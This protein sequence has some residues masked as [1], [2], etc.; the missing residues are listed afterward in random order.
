MINTPNSGS[1]I[2]LAFSS[3]NTVFASSKET[4]CL[5]RFDLA[6]NVPTKKDQILNINYVK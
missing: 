4:L 1:Y 3:S 2:N 6:Y 5:I